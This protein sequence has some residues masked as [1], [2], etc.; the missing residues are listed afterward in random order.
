[1]V[2]ERGIRKFPCLVREASSDDD[3]D[4]V[5]AGDV[6]QNLHVYVRSRRPPRLRDFS[7]PLLHTIV[8]V[9]AASRLVHVQINTQR[10]RVSVP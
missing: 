9:A 1:M 5:G 10:S 3:L 8:P 4:L 6:K 7:D 2:Y